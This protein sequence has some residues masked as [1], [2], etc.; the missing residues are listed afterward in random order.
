M[1]SDLHNDLKK[2]LLVFAWER[3]KDDNKNTSIGKSVEGDYSILVE[4][5]MEKFWIWRVFRKD[6]W[7]MDSSNYP[8][9]NCDNE[10]DATNLA[11][12]VASTHYHKNNKT[13]WK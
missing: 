10:R 8:K 11:I 1:I 2:N 4:C 6:E 13:V 12:E 9:G 3:M 5:V 7:I